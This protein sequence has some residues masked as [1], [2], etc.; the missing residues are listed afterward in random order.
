MSIWRVLVP[1]WECEVEADDEGEALMEADS[2]FNF[3]GEA[4]AECIEDEEA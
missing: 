4:R 1:Q 2:L 3:M